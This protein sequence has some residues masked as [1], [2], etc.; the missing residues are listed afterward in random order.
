MDLSF[1]K[2]YFRNSFPWGN[3]PWAAPA[4]ADLPWGELEHLRQ[5]AAASGAFSLPGADGDA[6]GLGP[7]GA[8]CGQ[9]QGRWDGADQRGRMLLCSGDAAGSS[10][11]ISWQ[12]FCLPNLISPPWEPVGREGEPAGCNQAWGRLSWGLC[13]CPAAGHSL[14]LP[15]GRDGAA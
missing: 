6:G 3:V 5:G 2:H 12:G 13:V 9:H 11:R 14:L 8:T 1:R 15:V 4:G 10:L 7:A